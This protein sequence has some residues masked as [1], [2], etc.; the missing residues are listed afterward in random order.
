MTP[1]QLIALA[2]RCVKCGL[3]LPHCP[4][5]RL[6]RDESESPRGRIALIQGWAGGQL[7]QSPKLAG[8][9]DRCLGCRACESACPSLVAYGRLADGAKA[10]RTARLPPWR[11]GLKRLR[12]RTLSDSRATRALARAAALYARLGLAGLAERL[13]A[14]RIPALRPYHRLAR[15]IPDLAL[16]VTPAEPPGPDLELFAGCMG[17]LAQGRAMAAALRLLDAL[18]L[19][20]RVAQGQRCC[21]AL[22]RHN[23]FPAEAERTRAALA[24]DLGP[25]RLVGLGSAC[26]AELKEHWDGAGRPIE[27][28]ELCDFLDRLAPL[29]GLALR[30]LGRPVL[31]H[32]PCS[33][34]HLLGGNAAVYR[35][36][37]R[38]PG[39]DLRPLPGGD[40][41]CGAAGTYLLEQPAL[42]ESL[43]AEKLAPLKG[44]GG[45]RVVTTNP[46][47]ALHLAAGLRE[48]GL[49]IDVRHPVELLWEAAQTQQGCDSDG[50]V[51]G[52]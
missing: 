5:Y 43:L 27:V 34:R 24:R 10:A 21:G 39:L 17:G 16:P 19:K 41:C 20:A 35:L 32:E 31:V 40:D 11:R 18:G 6:L 8:H 33:H 25:V 3:C 23:G 30:P 1:D 13:G 37:G 28:I 7:G 26:I 42:A 36:L 38:I 15:V 12:I 22:L 46:G 52:G 9:L 2:D 14:A 50:R 44:L 4:T 51:I 45:A 48:R 47:C 29:A 49:D